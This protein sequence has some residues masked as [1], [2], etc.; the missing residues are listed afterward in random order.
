M[1]EMSNK[2]GGVIII[3][4]HVQ[5]LSNTR[6]LG[7]S[8]IPVIVVDKNNCLARY[9]RYCKKFFYCPDYISPDF[10]DFLISL[11]EKE[12]LQGWSLIP[13]NDHAVIS[14]SQNRSKLEKYFKIITP[15]LEIITNIYDKSKL[16]HIAQEVNVHIPK[17]YFLE[18]SRVI[19]DNI[20]Y[21]V[22]TKGRYG[23]SFYKATSKKVFFSTSA[24]E[25]KRHLVEIEK[26]FQ[27][28]ETFTQEYI[29]YDGSNKT[30]SF[31]AFCI[32][33]EIKTHWVGKKVREHPI[34]FGTAT[35]ARSVECDELLEPSSKLIKALNYTGVCEVEFLLDPADSKY[36]L[37]EINARTWLWVGL[38]NACGVNFALMIYNYLNRL[39]IDFPK[40]YE[41]GVNWVNYLTDIVFSFQSIIKGQLTIKQY[42]NEFKGRTVNA[43]FSWKDILPGIMFLFLSIY[44]AI[45]RK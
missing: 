1:M 23:L 32:N 39:P 17:T 14:I 16:L 8:G 27:I 15:G 12:N 5:G 19:F 25:L 13:S 3:E 38:S 7:E 42:I 26:S 28:T 22:L 30:L 34:R 36:K 10:V 40:N 29:P 35:L 11:A 21:P 43:I 20:H 2:K 4:G 45:K 33:G 24:K 41:V 44:I 37:I 9:S 6:S 18:S 31:T